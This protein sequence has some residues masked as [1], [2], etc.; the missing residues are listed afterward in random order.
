MSL[1]EW[2]SKR[3][4]IT[5]LIIL[6]FAYIL[7]II[8]PNLYMMGGDLSGHILASMRLH[9]TSPWETSNL[10]NNSFAQLVQY[11]HGYTTMLLPFILYEIFFNLFNLT[12]NEP[13]L[14]FIHSILGILSLASIYYFL[15]L[16]F[17]YK[18]AIFAISLIAVIPTHIGFSRSHMGF[19]LIQSIFL[20]LSLSFLFNLIKED[21]LK[22]KIGYFVAT[23]FYIGADLSF[24]VG[25]FFHVLYIYLLKMEQGREEIIRT[26]KRIYFNFYTLIF[27]ILPIIIYLIAA[28][29]LASKGINSGYLLRLFGKFDAANPFSFKPLIVSAWLIELIGPIF[30]IFILSLAKFKEIITKPKLLFMITMFATYFI[31]LSLKTTNIEKN[32]VFFMAS[33]LIMIPL[34]LFFKNK[35]FKIIF[36]LTILL[37]MIYSLSVIY[38]F[39]IGFDTPSSHGSINKELI[40]N[41]DYGVKTLGYLIRKDTFNLSNEALIKHSIQIEQLA[42][43]IDLESAEYFTGMFPQREFEDFER[44]DTFLIAYLKYEDK[45]KKIYLTNLNDKIPSFV[46][47]K[48]LI[49][50]GYIVDDKRILIELYSNKPIGKMTYYNTNIYNK[51]FDEEFGNMDSISKIELGFY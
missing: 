19:V 37:T 38:G 23:F 39:N 47:D 40:K 18:K 20:F 45:N 4:T 49:L 8:Y 27:I 31:L 3:E 28:F 6:F 51:K 15:K 34:D 7:R 14:I 41:N 43:Y 13:N 17:E 32:Y 5:I 21:K 25:L 11:D 29:L 46:K 2:I 50:V 36:I 42:F 9:L 33:P 1:R 10:I 44:F 26:Y 35:L 30:I 48:N 16:N 22:W 12:I 24:F